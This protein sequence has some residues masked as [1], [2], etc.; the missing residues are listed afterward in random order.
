MNFLSKL[1][2]RP[3]PAPK[4]GVTIIEDAVAKTLGSGK[5][6]FV[7]AVLSEP[8]S[9]AAEMVIGIKG[10][11]QEGLSPASARAASSSPRLSWNGR[12]IKRLN[13]EKLTPQRN[14]AKSFRPWSV[15]PRRG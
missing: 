11:L 7:M 9:R 1:F 14:F 6:G 13:G 4:T 12:D 8:D 15:P 10:D 5:R 2:H 3:E